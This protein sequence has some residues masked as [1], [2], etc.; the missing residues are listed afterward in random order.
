MSSPA[1]TLEHSSNIGIPNNR[2]VFIST[3]NRLLSPFRRENG[4]VLRRVLFFAGLLRR[5]SC[6]PVA[7]TK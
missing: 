1:V 6:P 4:G 7:R 2:P 5:P 3:A